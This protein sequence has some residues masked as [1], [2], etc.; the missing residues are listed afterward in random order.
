MGYQPT[1]SHKQVPEIS[2][3]VDWIQCFGIYYNISVK[4]KAG[5][6]SDRIPEHY[7]WGFTAWPS[8]PMDSL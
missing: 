1:G 5:S 3:I 8:G 2:D 6:R 4:A 7:S